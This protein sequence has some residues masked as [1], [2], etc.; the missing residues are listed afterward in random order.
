VPPLYDAL[1]AAIRQRVAQRAA[2]VQRAATLLVG[3]ICEHCLDAPASLV[4]PAPW[5]GDMGVCI[6]CAHAMAAGDTD[7]QAR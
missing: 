1:T 7:S 5:G 4:Q 6:A 3:H 2:R